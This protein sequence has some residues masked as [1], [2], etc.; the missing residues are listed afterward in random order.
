M[1]RP[2]SNDNSGL[3]SVIPP[4]GGGTSDNSRRILAGG[5]YGIGLVSALCSV[6]AHGMLPEQMRIHWTLGIGPYYGP[7]FASTVLMLTVFPVGIAVAASL[8]CVVDAR[9]RDAP[10]F[11]GLRPVYIITVLSTLDIL[12]GVHITLILGNL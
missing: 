3:A 4:L 6:I 11:A 10:P 8:T 5:G 2:A 1:K 12:L 9:L 7:E